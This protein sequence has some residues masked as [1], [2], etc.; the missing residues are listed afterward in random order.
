MRWLIL[1]D[2]HDKIRQANEIIERVPHDQLLL[3]GDF[4]DDFRTGV[5]DAADTAKQV[6]RWLNA[7]NTT[8]LLGK[9]IKPPGCC[10]HLPPEPTGRASATQASAG[11]HVTSVLPWRIQFRSASTCSGFRILSARRA[12][13]LLM[14]YASITSAR[15]AWFSCGRRAQP[16][17]RRFT[18][19]P[20]CCKKSYFIWS[21]RS[22]Y[23][24]IWLARCIV[25]RQWL[26]V[27][28]R[29]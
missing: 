18:N 21:G 15:S 2:I 24:F 12:L 8:C 26:R 9:V 28:S 20:E 3:L 23:R 19:A 17:V 27:R 5:T 11:L 6:K 25:S 22:G 1:P 7:A 10:P 14:L 4:F 16:V 29:K 13:A